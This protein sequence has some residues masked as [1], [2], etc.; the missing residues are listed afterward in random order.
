[1]ASRA[2]RRVPA[3]LRAASAVALLW[4]ASPGHTLALGAAVLAAAAAAALVVVATGLLVGA[5]PAVVGAGLGSA[6]GRRLLLVLA[7]FGALALA[8]TVLGALQSGLTD[9]LRLRVADAV[10]DR[11]M[12]AGSGPYG[13]AHLE[14][15]AHADTLRLA[16]GPGTRPDALAE[17]VPEV[18]Q[19]RLQALALIGLLAPLAWWAPVVLCAAGALTYRTNL[20]IARSVHGTMSA[21]S[22][23]IRRSGYFR[24]LAVDAG[25]AKEIRVFG[26]GEWAAGRMTEVWRTA[27]TAVWSARR[28]ATGRAYG[29]VLFL[30]LAEGLVLG[31]AA[32]SAVHGE[33]S[34]ARLVIVVQAAL[35]LPVLG[36]AGD[37]DYL[38]RD[39][40]L[41]LRSLAAL[42][43]RA[44]AS[45]ARTDA[46]ART[47]G[48]PRREIAVESVSFTYPGTGRTV[49]DGL[50]LRIPAG[51]SVAIVG[52]NGEG[53]TTLIKLLARLY[54]P[55]GGRITVDGT[56]IRAAGPDA[57]RRRLAV[58]F[59]DFVKYPLPLRANVGFGDLAAA[60]DRAAL[61]EALAAAGG[62]ALVDRLGAGWDTVLSRQFT[63]GADLSGGQ[64]QQIALARALLAARHGA[65]LV[66]DEPTAGLDARAEAEFFD[67]FLGVAR[68]ATT[69]LISH[70]FSGVRRADLIHVLDGGRVA[71]SG[72]H[73]Q[74]MA[75]GGRYA[76]MYALQAARFTEEDDAP[77]PGPVPV[78]M[79][80]PREMPYKETESET[81]DD[82]IGS[83]RRRFGGPLAAL[84]TLIRGAFREAK[85]GAALGLLLVPA[86]AGVAALQALWLR[87]MA[88]GAQRGA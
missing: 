82:E 2:D 84:G 71:E 26:L 39:A 18:V 59:Q 88:D 29:A 77:G 66:L 65:V 80:V 1:M 21:T 6:A 16:T 61:E 70:R 28:A 9:A 3:P 68:G 79:P 43:E 20:G 10:D 52:A 38:V 12:A 11:V 48:P 72:T 44:A 45:P 19:P 75:L 57:W 46:A 8:R 37:F 47:L 58:V 50:S 14:D 69:V 64:W 74:L 13:I 25:P 32:H 15:P 55:D 5:L 36:W 33:L 87:D 49:L 56:D 35:G 62:A 31:Y 85:G 51:S 78:P 63:G 40:L 42:E 86:G 22:G 41:G 17:L 30:V 67:R 53:K 83:D 76:R 23:A 4:R 60:E 81:D 7:A 34:L 27:M 54:E 24:G 73:G